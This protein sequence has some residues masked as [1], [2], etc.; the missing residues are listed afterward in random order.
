MEG[1]K[2]LHIV[3]R[4]DDEMCLKQFFYSC[5]RDYFGEGLKENDLVEISLSEFKDLAWCF[6]HLEDFEA[7]YEEELG[8]FLS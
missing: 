6:N 2:V 7:T 3:L 8:K 4:I 1:D 5:E